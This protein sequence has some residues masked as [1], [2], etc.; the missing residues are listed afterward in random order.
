M[1]FLFR[2]LLV[3]ILA[4]IFAYNIVTN[5]EVKKHDHP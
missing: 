1:S 5:I 3:L 2:L 4:G